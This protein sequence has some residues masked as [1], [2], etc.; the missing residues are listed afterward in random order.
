[1]VEFF[2][3]K[4]IGIGRSLAVLRLHCR[5]FVG[6]ACSSSTV[7]CLPLAGRVQVRGSSSLSWALRFVQTG[8]ERTRSYSSAL[9]LP[10]L[11]HC[12]SEDFSFHRSATKDNDCLRTF[13][14]RSW[15]SCL[16]S[17][18]SDVCFLGSDNL[19]QIWSSWV[20]FRDKWQDLFVFDLIAYRYFGLL[21][22][23]RKKYY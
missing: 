12:A 23:I 16:S 4:D 17:P 14:S 20:S 2:R 13:G 7:H 9:P 19:S 1:M 3:R 10:Q 22:K 6:A 18:S 5:G 21:W 11:V 15:G 8:R